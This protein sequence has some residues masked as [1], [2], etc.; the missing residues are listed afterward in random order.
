MWSLD[1]YSL[2]S[3]WQ[4]NSPGPTPS[5]LICTNILATALRAVGKTRSGID[6]TFFVRHESQATGTF[7]LFAFGVFIS[8]PFESI[9]PAF[10]Q[11]FCKDEKKER[12]N[13]EATTPK[14]RFR[15][16]GEPRFW[17]S[18]R[19][20]LDDMLHE[21]AKVSGPEKNDLGGRSIA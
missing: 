14:K 4:S 17:R 12:F 16:V 19:L 6:H 15:S 13:E 8:S 10:R 18:I 1:E 11:L 2:A 21:R 3:A 9:L 20:Y 5:H 7:C